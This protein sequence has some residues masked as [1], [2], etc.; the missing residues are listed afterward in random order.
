MDA[1]PVL[2]FLSLGFVPIDWSIYL[3]IIEASQQGIA[4]AKIEF[5]GKPVTMFNADGTEAYRYIQVPAFER[6][7]C[8][9]HA[10]RM[11]PKYGSYA[12]S[13]LF[14]G[15]LRRIR[16]DAFK[17]TVNGTKVIKLDAIPEGVSVDLSGFLASVSFEV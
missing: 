9:M 12:N 1:C 6:R 16:D 7:H 10:F 2:C 4:M 8:D 15:M 5:K 14:V 3:T 11:H 13:D 17:N